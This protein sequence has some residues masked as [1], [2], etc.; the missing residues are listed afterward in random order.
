[1]SEHQCQCLTIKGSQCRNNAISNG[2]CHVHLT[3]CVKRLPIGSIPQME[4]DILLRIERALRQQTEKD[5]RQQAEKDLRQ[6]TRQQQG[7]KHS[8][9]RIIDDL[10][11]RDRVYP[12]NFFKNAKT[13]TPQEFDT[14]VK[15]DPQ[16]LIFSGDNVTGKT[17]M[18]YAVVGNNLSLIN[19]LAHIGGSRLLNLGDRNGQTPLVCAIMA[20]THEPDWDEFVPNLTIVRRL[21]ELGADVN[22]ADHGG[23]TPLYRIKMLDLEYVTDI[24][25]EATLKVIH[26]LEQY[27]AS[28]PQPNILFDDM[29]SDDQRKDPFRLKY[30]VDL[31]SAQRSYQTMEREKH[32]KQ[33]QWGEKLKKEEKQE[34]QRWTEIFKNPRIYEILFTCSAFRPDSDLFKHADFLL[35]TLNFYFPNNVTINLTIIDPLTDAP[36]E[37]EMDEHIKWLRRIS[38]KIN[39]NSVK[40]EKNEFLNHLMKHPKFYDFIFLVGCTRL[41]WVFGEAT[42]K[43]YKDLLKHSTILFIGDEKTYVK[44]VSG[45]VVHGDR[46]FTLGNYGDYHWRDLFVVHGRDNIPY[47][48]INV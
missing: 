19:H 14:C 1:M 8:K 34:T 2:L 22:I 6:R 16:S 4:K 39:I 42:T 18:H 48:T 5:L 47:Y 45:K 12:H 20:D 15:D 10:S 23:K 21:L 43:T 9:P 27:G 7:I 13:M 38:S 30:L 29:I 26:L 11:N 37:T 35:N 46:V 41:D 32:R 17:F 40:Y 44:Y 31:E 25:R 3:K 36:T 28:D 24:Q 33:I